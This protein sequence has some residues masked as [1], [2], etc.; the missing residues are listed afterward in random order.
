MMQTRNY[1]VLATLLCA[2]QLVTSRDSVLNS[3]N[4]IRRVVTLLQNMQKK[5]TAEGEAEKVLFDKFMC[6]CK[7]G[8]TTLEQSIADAEANGAKLSSDIERLEAQVSQLKAD[9]SAAQTDRAE[10]EAA[11]QAGTALRA[12]EAAAYSKTKAE[13]DSNIAALGKAVAAIEKGS[14]GFLQTSVAGS[15]RRLSVSMDLDSVDRD[16]LSAFLSRSQG[17]YAPQSGQISGIL[18]NMKDTMAKD[19]AAA[20]DAEDQSKADFESMAAAKTKQ[21]EALTHE[22]ETKM[23]RSG[24]AQVELVNAK[25]DQD[26]TAKSLREDTAF[27]AD[28][29]K[30]CASKQGEWD[31]RSKTRSEELVAL[32]DT[33]KILNDDDALELFKKTLPTPSLIQVRVGKKEIKQKALAVLHRATHRDF[34]LDLIEMALKGRTST[35]G[36]EKVIKMIDDMVALL[37][38]E[39][40][41]DDAKKA[42]CESTLDKTE[43]QLKQTE[44]A[45]SDLEKA[46]DDA[47]ERTATLADEIKAIAAGIKALDKQVAEAT[48]QRKE[49]HDENSETLANDASAVELLG[50]AKNRLQKFYNPKLYKEA[51]KREL[52]EEERITV[53]N[54]GTLAPTA[55]PGGIAGTGVT[56]LQETE[57]P[58]PPPDTWGAYSKKSGESAGVLTMIDMLVGD[59]DKEI[60]EVSTEEKENQKEYEQFMSDS[61]EKRALDAKSIADKE[62]AKADLEASLV[63]LAAETKSKKMEAMATAESIS[64]LHQECDWLTTNFEARKEARSG[65]IESLKNAKAVLSGADFSLLQTVSASRHTL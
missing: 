35:A 39:Q 1:I 10:A 43:D 55:A 65:E 45:I 40:S 9:I 34:R 30:N 31:A 47:K 25:E 48:E 58:A 44:L 60:Q 21:I 57:A 50:Y 38:K 29:Q 14:S 46:T 19:L 37:G 61:A 22:L 54:G 5:V 12:K 52:S 63:K 8:G 13:A 41:D 24:E 56:A 23:T 2:P 20:T 17:S 7:T 3:A 33:I 15:L 28:M 26:D 59:L 62:G 27:L 32:A 6:Y 51:P 49:E 36:F 11:L 53:N 16:M 4:P 18:Q 42:Y 64:N